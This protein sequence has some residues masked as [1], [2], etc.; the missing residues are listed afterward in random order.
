[1]QFMLADSWKNAIL[2]KLISG[3]AFVKKNV[4]SPISEK[5]F[6][7]TLETML[8]HSASI[9]THEVNIKWREKYK[10]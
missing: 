2:E 9:M 8:A 1:M 4:Y 7:A 10:L 5:Y 6:F 3:E